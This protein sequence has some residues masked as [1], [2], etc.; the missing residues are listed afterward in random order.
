VVE[1]LEVYLDRH[2]AEQLDEGQARRLAAAAQSFCRRFGADKI[3]LGV[4]A[5]LGGY[6]VRD[7]RAD[8]ELLRVARSVAQRLAEWLRHEDYLPASRPG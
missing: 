8:C 7:A 2:G 1:L 6:L 5:F 3:L 4:E